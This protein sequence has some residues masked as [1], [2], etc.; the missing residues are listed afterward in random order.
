M[1]MDKEVKAM[2]EAISY[3][4]DCDERGRERFVY[5]LTHRFFP[6]GELRPRVKPLFLDVSEE[7]PVTNKR[8]RL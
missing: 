4:V 5:H 7:T 1:K 8:K 6:D 2:H 3:M